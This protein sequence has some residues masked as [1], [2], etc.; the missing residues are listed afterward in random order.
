MDE[1]LLA[2]H[3]ESEASAA[4]IVGGDSPLTPLGREQARAL[5][6]R[7]ASFPVDICLTSG[8][9]RARETAAIALA[10]RDVK[11]EIVR[12]L[13]D[14]RFGEFDGRPLEEYRDW[15][16]AHPPTEGVPQGESRADTLRRFARAFRTVLVR[17]EQHALVVAHGLTIRALLDDRPRPVVAGAPYGFSVLLTRAELETAVEHVER[18]CESPSW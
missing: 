7:L 12:E 14:V 16:A 15:V 17:T 4:R 6:E 18:W 5:G 3:G 13:G 2:R 11:V 8:A 1:V 10:G 9:V